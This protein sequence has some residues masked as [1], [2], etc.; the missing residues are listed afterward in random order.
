MYIAKKS[1]ILFFQVTVSSL[2]IIYQNLMK[3][4]SV[5]GNSTSHTP[6]SFLLSYTKSPDLSG[7]LDGPFTHIYF[8]TL[9]SGKIVS[10]SHKFSK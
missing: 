1:N 2:L 9:T 10:P 5:N 4:V 7:T 6:V 3:G 8:E